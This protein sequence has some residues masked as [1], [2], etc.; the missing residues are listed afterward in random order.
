LINLG[1]E[2]QGRGNLD[3]AISLYSKAINIY[4]QSHIAYFNRGLCWMK[5]S[6]KQKAEKDFRRAVELDPSLQKM[7][8]NWDLFFNV[9]D[10][11]E[12]HKIKNTFT[13]DYQLI[14]KEKEL[15]ENR[16]LIEENGIK[17]HDE[18]IRKPFYLLIFYLK[19]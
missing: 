1:L 3:K 9:T 14:K 13:Y 7:I 5:K 2:E 17:K 15:K 19:N 10:Y 18:N 11:R 12:K 4:P 6:N 8:P 16:I